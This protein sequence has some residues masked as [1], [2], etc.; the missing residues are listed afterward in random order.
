MAATTLIG[1]VLC[2]GVGA[3]Q[4]AQSASVHFIDSP[5]AQYFRAT[6]AEQQINSRELSATLKSLL[7]FQNIGSLTTASSTKVSFCWLARSGR[8]LVKCC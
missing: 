1:L 3:L 2:L 5:T 6:S 4:L 8:Q 7:S